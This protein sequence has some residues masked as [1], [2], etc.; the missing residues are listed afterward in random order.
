MFFFWGTSAGVTSLCAFSVRTHCVLTVFL[1]VCPYR[2]AS[3]TKNFTACL[4][5]NTFL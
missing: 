4:S 1:R 5:H 3:V 2:A